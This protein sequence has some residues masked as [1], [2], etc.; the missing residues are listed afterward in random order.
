MPCNY[1]NR[2][3]L[4]GPGFLAG[5]AGSAFSNGMHL[6][7]HMLRW[8]F[9]ANSRFESTLRVCCN[10]SSETFVENGMQ[11]TFVLSLVLEQRVE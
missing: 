7:K 2:N 5:P 4:G 8:R 9:S 6:C 1:Y 11:R 3:E 10:K